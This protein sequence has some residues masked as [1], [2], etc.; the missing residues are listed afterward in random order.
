MKVED[1]YVATEGI[2]EEVEPP[3]LQVIAVGGEDSSSEDS[4]S[5]SEES[6]VK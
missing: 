2:L 4:S 6:D 3:V 1:Q 5:E